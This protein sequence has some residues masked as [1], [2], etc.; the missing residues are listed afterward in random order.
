MKL[1]FVD[2]GVL[3]AAGRGTQEVSDVAMSI[4]NDPEREFASSS[5]FC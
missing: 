1:T 2:S 4:L 5:S 3:I